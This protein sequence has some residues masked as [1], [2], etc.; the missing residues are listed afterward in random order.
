M[1]AASWEVA[2]AAHDISQFW[3]RWLEQITLIKYAA[4]KAGFVWQTN[5]FF[6]HHLFGMCNSYAANDNV[7]DV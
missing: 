2:D 7:N 6:L 5:L 1:P 3:K 4:K